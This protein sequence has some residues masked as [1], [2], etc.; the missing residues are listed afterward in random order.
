MEYITALTPEQQD[1]CNALNRRTE[2][3]V[4]KTTYGLLDGK[5]NLDTTAVKKA[6]D[7]A[8]EEVRKAQEVTEERKKDVPQPNDEVS[9]RK[10]NPGGTEGKKDTKDDKS[11]SSGKE[12]TLE[13]KDDAR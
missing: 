13:K 3:S 4:L 5:G 10:D 12:A 11:R 8:A 1:S 6:E 9:P 2:F 7:K